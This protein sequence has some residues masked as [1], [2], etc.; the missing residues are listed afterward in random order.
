MAEWIPKGFG[1]TFYKKTEQKGAKGTVTL[2]PEVRGRMGPGTAAFVPVSPT[3]G[4]R[5]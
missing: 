5:S 1:N 4:P 3:R 2:F